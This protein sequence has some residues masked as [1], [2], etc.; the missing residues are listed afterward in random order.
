MKKIQIVF[1]SLLALQGALG[2]CALP[3]AAANT[4]NAQNSLIEAGSLEEGLAAFKAKDYG[5]ALKILTP[6]AG[7][8]NTKAQGTLSRMYGNGWGVVKDRVLASQMARPAA[9][10]GDA[11]AQ[12]VIGNA[13]S[14]GIGVSKDYAE[15]LKWFRFASAQN[16]DVAQNNIGL[17]Y[18][19][20]FGVTKDY[21][22]ALKWFRLAS[23]QN[24]DGAQSNIGFMYL[25]GFGVTKDYAEAL[26]WF[27]LASAQNYDVAQNN[28][29]VMY[30]QGFGVT[31]DYAEAL[32]WYRLG[33]DQQHAL[34]QANIGFMYRQGFGVTKDYAEALRWFRLA[35]AQD[36]AFGQA[37]LGEMYRNGFGVSIDFNEALRLQKLSANQSNSGGQGSLGYHYLEGVGVAKDHAQAR[38]YFLL[39]AAQGSSMA[40]ANLGHM[41]EYGLGVSQDNDEAARWYLLADAQ[42]LEFAKTRLTRSLQMQRVTERVRGQSPNMNFT[43]ITTAGQPSNDQLATNQAAESKAKEEAQQ[44]ESVRIAQLAKDKEKSLIA[45]ALNSKEQERLALEVKAKEQLL[46]NQRMAAELALLRAEVDKN[47]VV[48]PEILANRKALVIGN[49]SYRFV[50][51]LKNAREDARTMAASLIKVGYSVT[52]KLD[53][54]EREMKTVLRN[55]AGTVEGG[56]EVAF[57]FA[58][59]GVQIANSNYLVPIDVNGEG[60][61]QMRDEA[62]SLQ[63][64]LDDMSEKKAKFTLAIIDACRDNPFKVAGRAIGSSSRGLAPTTAAT[65][66]IV[67]FSAGTGQRALDSLGP[68]DKSKNGLFTRVFVSE[69]QKPSV[70]IDKLLRETRKEVVRLAKTVG[71][72]QVPAI[73][74]QVVGDFYFKK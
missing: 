54:S 64:V 59:H 44:K 36:D 50:T 1:I 40:Q 30:R 16:Y 60:E 61:I 23:A 45:Q 72:D 21:A 71:H 2:Y 28:I 69:M 37:Q 62:I 5:K 42:G 13:Y 49:D 46:E 10:A 17:M 73:Y 6:I 39:A 43:D 58:G 57:F 74:D 18:L 24:Y 4:G 70:P 25:R 63:R 53:L 33:A 11:T 20:G 15:A 65:G 38:K 51:Q 7:R 68:N 26:K 27:R 41:H 14:N 35:V 29:G 12:N 56:D 22:E 9:E 67:I 55:F 48:K 19:R 52:L 3:S 34:S 66:Q 31:K 47:K 32:K 8:G